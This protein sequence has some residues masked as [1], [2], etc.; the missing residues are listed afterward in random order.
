MEAR[1]L[2]RCGHGIEPPERQVTREQSEVRRKNC[3]DCLTGLAVTEGARAA[4]LLGWL[5]WGQAETWLVPRGG[6]LSS[7]GGP[8]LC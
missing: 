3:Q 2:L 1:S 4:D 7:F 8:G 5:G 6:I